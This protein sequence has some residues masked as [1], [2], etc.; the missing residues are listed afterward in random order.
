MVGTLIR[1]SLRPRT[2]RGLGRD[3]AGAK[4]RSDRITITFPVHPL[5]GVE[6]VLVRVERWAGQGRRFAIVEHPG[7]GTLRLPL[8]WTDR[9]RPWVSPCVKGR[10]VRL[11]VGALLKLAG[12][13]DVALGR[14]LA[15]CE[16]GAIG[17]AA[18]NASEGE[19]GHGE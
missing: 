4:L 7:R 18:A 5:V 15:S 9:G 8:D 17:Q 13:L 1:R 12:A 3:G 16:P 2:R 11:A 14:T 10:P 19:D 6:L